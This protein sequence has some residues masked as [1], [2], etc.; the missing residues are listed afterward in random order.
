MLQIPSCRS[1]ALHINNSNTII[2][3]SSEFCPLEFVHD[4]RNELDYVRRVDF[5]SNKKIM[6]IIIFK[7]M[8]RIDIITLF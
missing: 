2:D 7:S 1:H 8:K 6:I 3:G 5:F 4:F